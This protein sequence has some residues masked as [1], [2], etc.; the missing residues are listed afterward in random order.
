[1]IPPTLCRI[2]R[3]RKSLPGEKA[4]G[5]LC[6]TVFLG[7]HLGE[8]LFCGFACTDFWPGNS[9]LSAH[10]PSLPHDNL[11]HVTCDAIVRCPNAPKVFE[12][13]IIVISTFPNAYYGMDF[14]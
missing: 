7:L 11:L 5:A 8:K 3:N 6:Q 14:L 4:G 12:M 2:S 13:V 9:P 10:T 1:M